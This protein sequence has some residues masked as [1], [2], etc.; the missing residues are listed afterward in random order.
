MKRSFYSFV[1]TILALLCI[2]WPVAAFCNYQ[3]AFIID[4]HVGNFTAEIS[5][6]LPQT[7][8]EDKISQPIP[9]TLTDPYHNEKDISLL[10]E[11]DN[12]TIVPNENIAVEGSGKNRF[13]V[14]T[15]T[16]DEFGALSITIIA[17]ND[18]G[19]MSFQKFSLHVLPVN[20]GPVI[21]AIS[22]QNTIQD[23]ATA[24]IP[25]T[26]ADIDSQSLTLWYQI[27]DASLVDS[28]HFHDINPNGQVQISPG[29]IYDISLTV[30]P[31]N[32]A[33]GAVSITVFAKD[34]FHKIAQSVFTLN[35]NEAKY[36]VQT[37]VTGP[38]QITPTNPILKKYDQVVIRMKPD[39]GFMIKDV[40]VDG[41]SKGPMPRF[42]AYGT[43]PPSQLTAIFG[44][45]EEYT[46]NTGFNTGG[47]ISPVGP[48]KITQNKNQLFQ[49][50]TQFGY[51]LTDVLIDGQ[52]ID[53]VILYEFQNVKENHTI[54]AEFREASPPTAD[55]DANIKDGFLPLK[56]QFADKSYIE[57]NDDGDE[58]TDWLWDFGD[59]SAKSTSQNPIHYY[60]TEGQYTVML[61]TT[62]TGGLT[63]T[64]TQSNMIVVH[65]SDV[66]HNFSAD[67]TDINK[68]D[69]VQFTAQSNINTGVSWSWNFGD[70]STSTLKNPAHTYNSAGKYTVLLTITVAG[71]TYDK[72]KTNYIKVGGRSIKGQIR[73]GDTNGG[74]TG[75]PLAS[76]W[77]EVW[78]TGSS[79]IAYT[80]TDENG[81]Y[82]ITGLPPDTGF[83]VAA[84][85]P[86]GTNNYF[87][88][89]YNNQLS[90]ATAH[91]INLIEND[92]DNIDFVLKQVPQYGISGKI[93][94]GTN[95]LSN[96]EVT[97]YS[98][99]A[100]FSARTSSNALGN[101]TLTGLKWASDY[102]VYVIYDNAEYF[103]SIPDDQTIG[104]HIP[105]C[106]DTVSRWSLAREVTPTDP[107][108]EHIDLVLCQLGT[109]HGHV[110]DSNNQG[111]QNIWVNASSNLLMVE[112]GALSDENGEY[113]I[114]GLT[115]VG[116]AEVLTKGY[117]VEV[118]DE[119]YPYQAYSQK[120]QSTDAE[121][122]TANQSQQID[123]ILKKS[124]NISGRVLDIY[125]NPVPDVQLTAYSKAAPASRQGTTT[126]NANGMY[127]I[128][129]LPF[130]TDYIVAAFS[131]YFPPQ[132]YDQ[133]SQDDMDQA[134]PVSLAYGDVSGI[135]F[136]LD[137][138]A[139]IKG[140]IKISD[141]GTTQNAQY[142]WVDI[143]SQSQPDSG[144][145][146]R[147]DSD[148]Y[149]E[150]TGLDDS[151]TDYIIQVKLTGYQ[152]AYYHPTE[153]DT[154][155]YLW[156][157]AV[158]VAP[159][160]D[161]NR[162]LLIVK[163][164]A[165][166][167][168]VTFQ[169]EPVKG[170]QV[171]AYSESGGHGSSITN[172]N[173]LE[174]YAISGLPNGIY[175]VFV[176]SDDYADATIENV[177]VNGGNV[178][179]I[180]FV[181][182]LPERK[183]QGTVYELGDGKSVKLLVF[184][185][186]GDDSKIIELVGD[187]T[188]M[189]Y[190]IQAL[191]PFSDYKMQLYSNDYPDQVYN[192]QTSINDADSINLAT[193]N[194]T[195]IDITLNADV[196]IIKGLV[197][198][199]SA[200]SF[201][202]TAWVDVQSEDSNSQGAAEVKK[203][204]D[205]TDPV[206][207]AYTITGLAR[208]ENFLVHIWSDKYLTEYYENADNEDD[209]DRINTT[210]Y[211]T[212]DINFTLDPGATIF[213]KIVDE[214]KKGLGNIYVEASSDSTNYIRGAMSAFDGNFSVKGLKA[215][216]D[217]KL[218]ALKPGVDLPFFYNEDQTV[219]DRSLATSISTLAGNPPEL[220]IILSEGLSI[221]GTVRDALRNPIL[222]EKIWINISSE[223]R[224][225]DVGDYISKDGTYQISGLPSGQDYQVDAQPPSSSTYLPATKSNIE[226]GQSNVDFYL[227]TGSK[228]SGVVRTNTGEALRNV[229]VYLS[230][231]SQSLGK[232]VKTKSD[233][234]FEINGLPKA[235][236]YAIIA[237]PPENSS[238]VEFSEFGLVIETSITK[239]IVLLPAMEF[240][241][242]VYTADGLTPVKN[243]WVSAFSQSSDNFMKGQRTDK[244]GKFEIT[245]VPDATDFVIRVQA[246]GFLTQKL[247]NQSPGGADIQFQLVE[248]GSISGSVK[249]TSGQPLSDA[250]V[251]A[252]AT[253]VNDVI[254]V[255]TGSNGKFELDG[256]QKTDRFGSPIS[257]QITVEAQGYQA[258]TKVEIQV[259]DAVDFKMSTGGTISGTITDFNGNTPPQQY[260]IAINI[261]EKLD[262]G[263]LKI[264]P[265]KTNP[266]SDGQ[267][268]VKGLT[269]GVSYVIQVKSN[270][271][272]NLES[273]LQWVGQ[274]NKGVL[275]YNGTGDD[276][277]GPALEFSTGAV[278][279]FKFRGTF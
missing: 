1:W 178:E 221:A 217:Y 167:G 224:Q 144:G 61:T 248:S 218:K 236:D 216:G 109:I 199:P 87:E 106:D 71:N 90:F 220:E 75:V 208:G 267:F 254:V 80:Q 96:V 42:I 24:P 78:H 29:D 15:P 120:S 23:M 60:T 34:D 169:G 177:S 194:A 145:L 158:G 81:Y 249:N 30:I 102:I 51:V 232:W 182:A 49:I 244:E 62:A 128:T 135:D 141:N 192:N 94:N 245:N 85:P 92:K 209:A 238:Y 66:Y 93:H 223:S 190:T 253:K 270:I 118:F 264:P 170:L 138:G 159:S 84:F 97:V 89:Y 203:L 13:L 64:K 204:V 67:K 274:D 100:G 234:S 256:L 17:E 196:S 251:K 252:T 255:I 45:P 16:A 160:T 74:D 58:I 261:F 241:G 269:D 154:T 82:T 246:D 278:I 243:A 98:A 155:V 161:T 139:I 166:K 143:H 275:R 19:K 271:Q 134:E 48:V 79:P 125:N 91:T 25:F 277:E 20:D 173:D 180:D 40:I 174:N 69:T 126:S 133:K 229:R 186:D 258:Q 130:A 142:I 240:T 131:D 39:E 198:F 172:Q 171:I 108:T 46:I 70:G 77:V 239:D 197:E 263:G 18:S 191:K 279:D 140:I 7:I 88:E 8:L 27:S 233:G 259:G 105:I 132:Y 117:L 41:I 193:T 68:G 266:N 163:G 22:D 116:N 111:L 152:P 156:S 164:F 86:A 202:D 54:E 225:V 214:Y 28:I 276:K 72:S 157:Q 44:P 273:K 6:I 32:A 14:I 101:Y 176:S 37:A 124:A 112:N 76:Y 127:T 231:V 226:S 10:F 272:G 53:T 237:T 38:G 2:L 219:R 181:L 21:S 83:V 215:A 129:N 36:L 9:F 201:G 123:F 31:A 47:S 262:S 119:N 55:F 188:P 136:V 222:N 52:S 149:Y 103:Y 104:V 165:I 206:S 110:Y 265:I 95:G 107:V 65:P 26:I 230:S 175:T 162:N 57:N 242:Y 115:I 4:A 56:V 207:D 179:N 12:H 210:N 150:M 59:G 183:I 153:P 11:S 99:D 114:T 63:D 3:N 73:A 195:G 137:E 227:S 247:E 257:Y 268:S 5:P 200:A 121:R 168:L 205:T 146:V 113:T 228:I 260:K 35:I 43:N 50:Q 250:R 184:S 147:T 235:S 187:G 122:V 189:P 212:G 151:I 213:G 185:I 33:H 148:G 211:E